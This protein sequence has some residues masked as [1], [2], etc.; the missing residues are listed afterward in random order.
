MYVIRLQYNEHWKRGRAGILIVGPE[1]SE[2]TRGPY[3]Y[4]TVFLD[5]GISII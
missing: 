3:E 2:A 4:K 5:M 1:F